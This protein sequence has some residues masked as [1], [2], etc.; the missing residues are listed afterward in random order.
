MT[1]HIS[2]MKK[3][4][5]LTESTQ[6]AGSTLSYNQPPDFTFVYNAYLC[7]NPLV[8]MRITLTLTKAGTLETLKTL[9]KGVNYL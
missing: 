4:T 2:D 8:H 9:E 5:P 6:F 3:F 1:A 7:F